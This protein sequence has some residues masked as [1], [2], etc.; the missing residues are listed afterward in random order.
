[1]RALLTRFRLRHVNTGCL[2]RSHNVNLPQWGFKQSEV[3]CDKNK[4]SD[5][6]D[7]NIWNIERH[8]N[9]LSKFYYYV[10][11]FFFSSSFKSLFYLIIM[12]FITLKINY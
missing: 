5:Y 3:A 2:L 4:K 6:Q 9:E 1:V 8:W 12:I 11:F 7:N 10:F